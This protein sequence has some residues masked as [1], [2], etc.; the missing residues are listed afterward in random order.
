MY[1]NKLRR[2][3]TAPLAAIII[4][5][6]AGITE[7]KHMGVRLAPLLADGSLLHSLPPQTSLC[8]RPRGLEHNASLCSAASRPRAYAG[9]ECQ[10]R[11]GVYAYASIRGILPLLPAT[12]SSSC[13]LPARARNDMR[14]RLAVVGACDTF[15]PIKLLS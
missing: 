12:R 13:P 9:M 5:L 4:L 1:Y 8:T 6:I 14:R 3:A 11:T 7:Y 10:P 15:P 2:G